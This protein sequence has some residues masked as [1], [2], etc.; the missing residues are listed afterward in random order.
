MRGLNARLD[1]VGHL[2]IVPLPA[3]DGDAIS[4]TF[5][6]TAGICCFALIRVPH[7]RVDLVST[8]LLRAIADAAHHL[9][10]HDEMGHV[11]RSVPDGATAA[12]RDQPGPPVSAPKIEAPGTRGFVSLLHPLEVVW[13]H[14]HQVRSWLHRSHDLPCGIAVAAGEPDGVSDAHVLPLGV[15]GV[16]VVNMRARPPVRAPNSCRT[17]RGPRRSAPAM[18]T[19]P[20]WVR[21]WSHARVVRGRVR[22]HELVAREHRRDLVVV[23]SPRVH[24]RPQLAVGTAQPHRPPPSVPRAMVVACPYAEARNDAQHRRRVEGPCDDAQSALTLPPTV[25]H[26]SRMRTHWLVE[27]PSSGGPAAPF[28]TRVAGAGRHLPTTHLTTDDLMSTTRH[29]THIDLERLT[30]IHERRVSV[31]DD[32]SYSL[33]TAAAM[34]ALD[35]AQR[36]AASIDVVISCSITKLRDGLTQQMEP[37]MSSAVAHAIGAD[38]RD[39]VRRLE[40]LRRNAHRCDRREQL[41]SAGKRS[42][43]RWWS[44]GSTSRNSARMQP[45]TSGTS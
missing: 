35:R 29:H 37:T 41:D 12:P 44:A 25:T 7:E 33:A 43:A 23:G 27:E 40:R 19:P 10:L 38:K 39:D 1:R 21:R 5:D 34:D 4:A 22:G 30:G 11:E 17:R 32:D 13:R 8:R 24:P 36:D 9:L 2:V 14:Q 15:D 45:D 3:T 42:S 31:G 26:D 6:E 18:A 16:R 28:R 20:Q